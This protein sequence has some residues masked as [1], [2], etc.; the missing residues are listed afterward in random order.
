MLEREGPWLELGTLE[1]DDLAAAWAR[2][3]LVMDVLFSFSDRM[4]EGGWADPKDVPSSRLEAIVRDVFGGRDPALLEDAARPEVARDFD[5]LMAW[6][7]EQDA[8]LG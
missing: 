8:A 6:A 2:L 3:R 5:R 4:R 1:G 7:H